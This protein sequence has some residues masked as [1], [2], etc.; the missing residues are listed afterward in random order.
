MNEVI[1]LINVLLCFVFEEKVNICS[2]SNFMHS[3]TASEVDLKFIEFPAE[4][5]TISIYPVFFN[6]VNFIIE[7]QSHKL[8]IINHKKLK[9]LGVINIFL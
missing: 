9:K 1:E 5:K 8:L 6:W 4:Q 7:C 2:R 3:F